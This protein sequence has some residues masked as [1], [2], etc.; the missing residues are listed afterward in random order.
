M[1][2]VWYILGRFALLVILLFLLAPVILVFP[3]SF[4]ADA[5]VAWPPSGWSV[6]WYAALW[7]NAEMGLAFRNSLILAGLVTALT[8][9]IGIPAALAL[10][11]SEFMGKEALV[12]L[13]TMPLLLPSIVLGL[14]I[15]IIFVGQGLVG[16]FRGMVLAHLVLTLPYALRILMTGLVTMPANVEDAAA[17]LGASPLR[18]LWRVTLPLMAPAMVA[19]AA[20]SFIVS[21][22]EVVVSLFIAGT[23]LKLLPVSLYHYV[24]SRTDPMVAAVSALVV[25]GTLAMV[26]VVERA[27]GLRQAVSK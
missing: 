21:F 20:L 19:A 10:A 15:L 13:L 18:V 2:T 22:D 1:S 8:L 11:R 6:K 5:Y 4:S 14:A 7:Q 16:S 27:M 25:V 3:I 12:S 26:I 24:E 23:Q 17:S 9:A